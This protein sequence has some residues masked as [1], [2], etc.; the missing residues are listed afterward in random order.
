LKKE[1]NKSTVSEKIV[2]TGIGI[3]SAIGHSAHEVLHSLQAKKTGLGPCSFIDTYL[4]DELPVAEVK[5]SNEELMNMPGLN[6]SKTYTRASLLGILA[7]KEAIEQAGIVPDL[8]LKTG[9][10]SSTS[11]GGMDRTELFFKDYLDNPEKGKMKN[12]LGHDCAAATDDIAAF[13]NIHDYVSTIST[14]CSSAANAVMFGARLIKNNILDRVVVGGVDA[15]TKFTIN[16]FNTLMILDRTPCR[17]FD[18]TRSGL[19]IG[20]GAAYIVIESERTAL[21]AGKKILATLIGYGNACDAFHQTASSPEGTGPRLAML[22]AMEMANVKPEDI[23]YINA[24]GTGTPNNDLSEGI[25]IQSIFKDALPLLSSTKQFTGHTL[26][27]AGAIEA[28]ISI[29]AINNNLIFPNLNFSTPMKELTLKP[30]TEL[31]KEKEVNKVLSNSFG[32][33]GNNTTLIFSKY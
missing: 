30:V 6:K 9:L 4:K 8:S 16:G 19:N 1:T 2:I 32:F 26:G 11:V 14:A 12:V 20:E 5:H 27:A 31:I 3:V 24:H 21:A 25:A 23:D 22:K 15:L 13:F 33:G 28:V 7:A 17:P 29:L 18:E 10:I